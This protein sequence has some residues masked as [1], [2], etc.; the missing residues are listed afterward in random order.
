MSSA[1]GKDKDSKKARGVAPQAA[2]SL[3]FTAKALWPK[4]RGDTVDKK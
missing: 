1:V 3:R 4:D 2:K